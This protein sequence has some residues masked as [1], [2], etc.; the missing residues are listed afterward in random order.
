MPRPVD[1]NCNTC[2]AGFLSNIGS[3]LYTIFHRL[4]TIFT[5]IIGRQNAERPLQREREHGHINVNLKDSILAEIERDGRTTRQAICDKHPTVS[6]ETVITEIAQLEAIGRI[7]REGHGRDSY[8]VRGNNIALQN[9]TPMQ[10]YVQNSPKLSLDEAFRQLKPENEIE[11]RIVE[12]AEW[13]EGANWGMPRRGHPEGQ[14]VYHVLEVLK[15]VDTWCKEHNTPNV[16]RSKLRVI[17]MIHDTFKHKVDRSQGKSDENHHAMIARR[18]AE[19]IN[20]VDRETLSIIQHHDDAYNAWGRGQKNIQ[21]A[22]RLM[23]TLRKDGARIELYNAFYWCDSNTGDKHQEPYKWFQEYLRAP[24]DALQQAAPRPAQEVS[25]LEKRVLLSLQE[26][27][28]GITSVA[29]MQAKHADLLPT[30]EFRKLRSC[31][32]AMEQQGKLVKMGHGRNTTYR[33]KV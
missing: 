14:V 17:A 5:S 15:N 33:L 8:Y 22:D 10:V 24:G 7:K 21:K 6:R 25:E 16:D 27:A 12:N 28:D 26:S 2:Q 9:Q 30:E 3:F 13:I 31:L 11:R 20:I 19:R 32:E 18:F 1:N 4:T 23:E 29:K